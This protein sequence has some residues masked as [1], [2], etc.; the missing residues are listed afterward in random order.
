[1][2]AQEILPRFK[3]AIAKIGQVLWSIDDWSNIDKILEGV[4]FLNAQLRV[5]KSLFPVI[6]A[7]QKTLRNKSLPGQRAKRVRTLTLFTFGQESEK[8]KKQ[9]HKL[10]EKRQK[11]RK[12]LR[13]L[14]ES[15]HDAF[16][17]CGL[18]YTIEELLELDDVEFKILE[19]RISQL[20]HH[21]N[22]SDLLIRTDVDKAVDS[23][24]MAENLDDMAV[25]QFIKDIV[26]DFSK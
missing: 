8:A 14:C 23:A 24:D 18:S 22:L 20:I 5:Q 3:R 21:H 11:L 16:T 17:L 7:L 13:E 4:S 1:M 6:N 9:Y 2:S 12:R 26:C 15:D 25:N 19:T 10:Q